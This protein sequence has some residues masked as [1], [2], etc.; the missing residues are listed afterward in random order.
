MHQIATCW[1]H[2]E[3]EGLLQNKAHSRDAYVK[4]NLN[5]KWTPLNPIVFQ[6]CIVTTECHVKHPTK[7]CNLFMWR[8]GR[9]QPALVW[10]CTLQT[11]IKQ[12]ALAHRMGDLTLLI[13][14]LVPLLYL[15]E[16]NNF[17]KYFVYHEGVTIL[18][19]QLAE[20]LFLWEIHVITIIHEIFAH[21]EC[22]SLPQPT[23]PL[24]FWEITIH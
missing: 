18:L 1:F 16:W 11:S 24:Y 12:L 15:K 5:L 20:P 6:S 8:L 22:V 4:L 2:P 14:L 10:W 19:P 3:T 9:F 13:L 23:A 7:E 21:R 17:I